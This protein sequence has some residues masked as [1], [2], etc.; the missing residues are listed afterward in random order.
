MRVLALPVL[1]C[2]RCGDA[3]VLALVQV[4][5][6]CRR[7]IELRRRLTPA[8]SA[9]KRRFANARPRDAAGNFVAVQA[10]QAEVNAAAAEKG[11]K[12]DA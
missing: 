8:H 5:R 9:A 1:A 7:R 3:M 11:G 6:P 10:A 12:A 4:C 2:E